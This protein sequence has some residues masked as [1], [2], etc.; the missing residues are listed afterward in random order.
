[1]EEYRRKKELFDSIFDVNK[2][3]ALRA[4]GDRRFSHKVS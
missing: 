3:N 1:M 2:H 4:R